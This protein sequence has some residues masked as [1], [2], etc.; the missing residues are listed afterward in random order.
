MRLEAPAADVVNGIVRGYEIF[1]WKT[2]KFG[3]ATGEEMMA[4]FIKSEETTT[5]A[6]IEG[7]EEFTWYKLKAR[8][9]TSMGKGPNTTAHIARTLQDGKSISSMLF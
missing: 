5:I 6:L 2:D 7:L 8:A 9:Y 1:Y 4:D 3:N